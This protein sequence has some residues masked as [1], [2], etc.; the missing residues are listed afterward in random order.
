[1]T[2]DPEGGFLNISRANISVDFD[3]DWK[4]WENAAL[5]I[6]N[7]LKN[8]TLRSLVDNE[9]PVVD[10]KQLPSPSVAMTER[11]YTMFSFIAH[12]YIRGT[13]GDELLRVNRNV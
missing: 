10:F 8:R 5:N 11:I 6:P 12:A 7:L 9:L 13:D 1:M 2:L 3:S 4:A